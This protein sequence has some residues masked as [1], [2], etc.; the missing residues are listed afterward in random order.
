M[1]RVRYYVIHEYKYDDTQEIDRDVL[2]LSHK[3]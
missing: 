2:R 1:R 3:N